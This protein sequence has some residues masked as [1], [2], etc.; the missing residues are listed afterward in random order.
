MSVLKEPLLHFLL[1]GAVLFAVHGWASKRVGEAPGEIVIT[2]G[3][4]ASTVL[5]FTRTWQRPPSD[6]EL[7]GLIRD[8]VRD[9]VYYR[10]ALALGLDRDDVIIRRRLRQKME[11]ITED[12]AAQAQPTDDELNA[13]LSAHAEKFRSEP[14][15]TFRQVY[16][17]PETHGKN[18]ARDTAQLL[19][20]L[21]QAAGKV[22]ASTLSDSLLLDHAYNAIPAREVERL[23]GEQFAARL[24]TLALGH[25]QGPV[26]SGYG[27]HLAS[28]SERTDG[29]VPELEEVR[30]AVRREWDNA[31]RQQAAENY[32][33]ALLKRYV[34]TVER[35]APL[36]A[37]TAK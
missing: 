15:F 14:L 21:N 18:L 29:R 11:F 12:V 32:Y 36:A 1:L 20:R 10:E 31:R 35:A 7:E 6:E 9:E 24:G 26:V 13:Y 23:F 3:Q 33:E 8:R 34:V 22:D 30:D 2:K 5:G 19:A 27:T 16:L 28:V 17:N 4:V 37:D 25:W